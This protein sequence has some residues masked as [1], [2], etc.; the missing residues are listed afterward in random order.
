MKALHSA[1]CALLVV[2]CASAQ[3]EGRKLTPLEQARVDLG[4]GQSESAL[5]VMREL[6]RAAPEDLDIARTYAEAA[7]SAHHADALVA[8]TLAANLRRETAA[9]HYLLALAYFDRS[10]DAGGK[11]LEEFQRAI[12]LAPA[13]AELVYRFGLALVESER[14]KDALA[15]LERARELG[16]ERAALYLPLAQARARTGDRKG[17][18]AALSTFV[19]SRPS[20]KDV[21]RARKIVDALQD[22]FADFPEAARGRLNEGLGWLRN[23]DV[24]QRAVVSFE[25]I[26]R[27]YPDLPS[28]HALLGLAYQRVDDAGRAVDEFRRAIDL[29]PDVGKTYLYLGDL[30]LG[31]QRADAAREAFEKAVELN[32]L[33]DDGYQRLGDAALDRRNLPVAEHNFRIL[34]TLEPAEI[35][36]KSKLA[37]VL[38]LMGDF[39]GAEHELRLGLD[40][41]PENLELKLRMGLLFT[42]ARQKATTAEQRHRNSDEA[43]VWLREVLKVQPENVVAS[44]ALALLRPVGASEAGAAQP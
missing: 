14:F 4:R 28:I 6:H 24:P 25:E 23:A 43:A 37:A 27:D 40:K 12:I 44:R 20:P 33:L 17:A 11:A 21:A 32:P 36:P 31:R 8:E 35:G 13:S 10:A 3:K 15:P 16:P 41:D 7:V 26:L 34:T 30:Y 42:E 2:A 5:A 9:N 29:A 22:P 39:G 1:L 19:A 18:V 38:Q